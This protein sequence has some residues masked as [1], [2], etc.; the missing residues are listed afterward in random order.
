MNAGIPGKEDLRAFFP[1]CSHHPRL[2][3]AKYSELRTIDLLLFVV[4]S[5]SHYLL[6][7]GVSCG[8]CDGSGFPISRN[9]DSS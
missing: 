9:N 6:A 4:Y 8:R 1:V 3:A 2:S 5:S 7:V